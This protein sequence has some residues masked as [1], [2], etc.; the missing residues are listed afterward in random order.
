MC[1]QKSPTHAS[2]HS[3]RKKGKGCHT[4]RNAF[5]LETL[6]LSFF[7]RPAG[8]WVRGRSRRAHK[9]S[10]FRRRKKT[11]DFSTFAEEPAGVAEM[12]LHLGPGRARAYPPRA[13]RFAF[14]T[15]LK[16]LWFPS[17]PIWVT[18]ESCFEVIRRTRGARIFGALPNTSLVLPKIDAVP[19]DAGKGLNPVT[20]Q[21]VAYWPSSVRFTPCA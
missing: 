6:S 9:V 14:P 20:K 4:S 13:R 2:S 11:G 3:A 16:G 19:L 7:S 15:P 17:S 12:I 18:I 8:V 1:T 21:R 5:R 10:H